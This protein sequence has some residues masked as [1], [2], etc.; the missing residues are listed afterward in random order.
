MNQKDIKEIAGIIKGIRTDLPPTMRGWVDR[1]ALEFASYFERENNKKRLVTGKY[2][3]VNWIKFN[4]QQF[5]E[6]CGVK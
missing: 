6:W 5:L 1:L 2:S 4:R 3:R